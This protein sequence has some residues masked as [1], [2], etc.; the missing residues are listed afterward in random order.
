MVFDLISALFAAAMV[1]VLPGWFWAK[2][3]YAPSSDR[4]GRLAFGVALSITLTPAVALTASSL[5]GS[6]I[7]L[8][9][10]ASSVLFVFLSG[11]AAHLK[12]G[13]AKV[14]DEPLANHD[15][16]DPPE[17]PAVVRAARWL[18]LPAVMAVALV[19]GYIGPV[20]Y[21]WPYIR[22]IDQY[23]QSVMV[24][25]A[26]SGGEIR[27]FM[28]YPPGFH[29]TL[30]MVSRV[31]G[32]GPLELF[33]VLG[34]MFLLLPPLALYAL[35][36]RVWGVWAGVA[37]AFFSG[38]ILNSSYQYLVEARYLHMTAAQFLMAL[39][40]A[41]FLG[42]IAA[43]SPRSGL[44]LA[45]VG[46]SVVLYHPV[47]SFYTALL[48]GILAVCLLP[49][50]LWRERA[51]GVALTLSLGLL[52]ILAVVYAWG[53]YDL[54]TLAANL[55][56]G[57]G[58][59]TG[60][61]V[62]GAIG[63]QPVY[64]LAHL[65]LAVSGAVLW[66]GLIGMVFLI[67]DRKRASGPS[68]RPYAMA[69]FAVLAWVF[70]MFV[71][72]R[73][74]ASG[75]PERFE[76]DLGV[77]LALLAAFAIVTVARMATRA[78]HPKARLLAAVIAVPMVALAGWQAYSN[79]EEA[80]ARPVTANQPG[81]TARISMTPEFE[82]AG[83]W[84]RENN[85]GGN[86]I[87]T[88]Y[89]DG[90]PSRAMLAMGRYSAVQTFDEG[91]INRD[92]DLPPSGQQPPRDALFALENPASERTQEILAEYDVRYLVL[93]KGYEGNS[94]GPAWRL[95]EQSPDLYRKTFENESVVIYE[96]RE[97]G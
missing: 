32:L 52:G 42:L 61:A 79:L 81:E 88:P 34:P 76:R 48:L 91:R 44:L 69:R 19:R 14:S 10:A 30:A 13:P 27:D 46:S 16:D 20:L 11:L 70:I 74:S 97:T 55:L 65:P 83:E 22:G 75:F 77:P 23:I 96:P 51:T 64:S 73:T 58:G 41:A 94:G 86:I 17:R 85:T 50:L 49:Y 59:G 33:P 21:D 89:L 56:G 38:V 66:L 7:T 37:A 26:L 62:T 80:A 36:R 78:N 68:G 40:V 9:V 8:A 4:A 1:C 87:A 53:T 25:L 54:P 57:P 63:T 3:L 28:V 84:L 2:L 24:N 60:A 35:G 92:R 90:L 29:G 93:Y 31:S 71:G 15:P 47:S 39:A 5:L 6:G 67:S 43:P 12:L 72:S 18:A 45:L 82:A 95:F